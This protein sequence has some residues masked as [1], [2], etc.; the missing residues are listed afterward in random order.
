V[1]GWGLEQLSKYLNPGTTAVMLGSSGVGKS[2]LLNK[3]AE[4]EVMAVGSVR[5]KDSRGRHTTSHRQMIILKSGGMIID[6]PG[7][8][9]LG[10]WD[11]SDG[12]EL[13]FNDIEQYF[14]HCK[15]RNCRHQTEPDCAVK[16]A[17]RSG[18]LSNERWESYLRLND[19]AKYTGNK[20][21]YLLEKHRREK[22]LAKILRQHKAKPV[23]YRH[24]PC[25][26][27]FIC[28]VCGASVM[29]EEAGSKHRNHCPHCL[30]SIHA[31]NRP[32][33]RSSLCRGIMDPIGIWVR[34]DKEWALIHRCRRCGNLSSNRI[35]ADDNQELL[36]KIA[37]RPINT[38]PFGFQ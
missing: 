37:M 8:R 23:D 36:I 19:E 16:K 30:S 38:K 3:L 32:G 31:D 17:I 14:G 13:S 4:K 20:T 12:L 5:G 6:T 10:M 29:P 35:A 1:T 18:E 27:S 2:S 7:M 33:D 34:K 22:D 21:A 26:E 25:D 15:F 9:E 24:T 11:I 28:K